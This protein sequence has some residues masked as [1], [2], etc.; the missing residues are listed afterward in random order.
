MSENKNK[1]VN[2]VI[3][4]IITPVD[5]NENV[6]EAAFRAAIRRCLDAGVD[7]IFAGGSAGMGPLLADD[8]W[9]LAMEIARDEVDCDRVL[10]G[11]VIS[12][13]TRRAIEKIKILEKTGFNH[14]A[15]T[16]SFYYTLKRDQEFL[17]HFDNCRQATNMNMVVYNIPSCTHSSIP[18]S[19][20]DEMASKKWFTTIKESSGDRI[21]FKA[22][23]EISRQYGFDL[24]QGNEPDIAWGLSCGAKGI[25]PVCA[26]YEPQTFV[27]AWDASQCGDKE[28]LDLAQQRAD[29]IRDILLINSENWIA[30]I[31]YG[32]AS[33]GIGSGIPV[34]PLE[35]ISESSKKHINSLNV[36]DIR[37]EVQNVS[38]K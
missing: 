18:L 16:P 32:V 13:S 17:A 25:I 11:G 21:Y 33:L 27:A 28:M 7:G 38:Q 9:Q 23:M 31:M 14:M 36:T 37:L 5:S 12:T 34:L 1:A 20:L 26:N 2:G 3:V 4:P 6:D 22:A 19:V 29:Y 30:G 15:V 35:E 24:L 8:Q 10:L